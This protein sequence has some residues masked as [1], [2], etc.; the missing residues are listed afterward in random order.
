MNNVDNDNDDDGDGDDDNDNDT[1][2]ND[3]DDDPYKLKQ[4][5]KHKTICREVGY[6]YK[7]LLYTSFSNRSVEI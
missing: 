5:F 1:D 3:D 6:R 2:D 7:L 4:L